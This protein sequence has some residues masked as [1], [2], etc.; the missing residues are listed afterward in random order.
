MS[1]ELTKGTQMWE[2]RQ[3]PQQGKRSAAA[4]TQF[5]DSYKARP[6]ETPR[7]QRQQR[8]QENSRPSGYTAVTQP[9]LSGSNAGRGSTWL[10]WLRAIKLYVCMYAH[11]FV[12]SQGLSLFPDWI[13]SPNLLALNP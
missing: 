13:A 8:E 4:F 9:C 10:G 1:L 7:G 12:L 2:A 11:M 5:G 3:T 6:E